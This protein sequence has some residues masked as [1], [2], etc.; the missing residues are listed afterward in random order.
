M[1][2]SKHIS[3]DEL[4]NVEKRERKGGV[5]EKNNVE[6]LKIVNH[7]SRVIVDEWHAPGDYPFISWDGI[8]W[9]FPFGKKTIIFPS[10][11]EINNT[12][13]CEIF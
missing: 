12:N 5:W 9:F 7:K 8:P 6:E 3:K 11:H 13:F 4:N 10:P 1:I 2:I